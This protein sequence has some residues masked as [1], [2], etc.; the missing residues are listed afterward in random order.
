MSTFE[1]I[2]GQPVADLIQDLIKGKTLVKVSIHSKDFERLT[3]LLAIHVEKDRIIRFQVD[4]PEGLWIALQKLHQPVVRF[5]FL[6]QDRLPHRFEV[7][8]DDNEAEGWLPYPEVIERYQLRSDFRLKAPAN[9]YATA[10]INEAEFKMALDNISLGGIF[11]HCPNSAK[12]LLFKDQIIESL[13]LVF[14]FGG[15]FQMISIDRA[16]VRRIA[17]RT[18]H[19]HFGVAFE[20]AVINAEVKKRLAHL[21][22]GLQREYLQNQLNE[23]R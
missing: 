22:Y 9:A 3:V 20:F 1:K 6:S 21:L 16:V 14:T 13:S 18:H 19:R 10:L 12:A 17:G 7:P 15:E 23:E 8:F 11:C 2:T 4:P 5:E